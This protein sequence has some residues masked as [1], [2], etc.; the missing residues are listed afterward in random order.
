MTMQAKFT[1][2]K[3]F[4]R[5]KATLKLIFFITTRSV[6]LTRLLFVKKIIRLACHGGNT[7]G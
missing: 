5:K 2:K 1:K 6:R 4:T 3:S 7:G